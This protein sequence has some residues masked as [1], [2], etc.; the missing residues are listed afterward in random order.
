M[1]GVRRLMEELV[2]DVRVLAPSSASDRAGDR[3]EALDRIVDRLHLRELHRTGERSGGGGRYR[4]VEERGDQIDLLV[5]R[6]ARV[7]ARVAAVHRRLCDRGEQLRRE[8][9]ELEAGEHA[10]EEL[11]QS[12][13]ADEQHRALVARLD[14]DDRRAEDGAERLAHVEEARAVEFRTAI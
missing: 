14:A 12:T 5:H 6:S 8:A 3:R 11:E 1:G 7:V 9:V 4:S 2:A 13:A 10:I